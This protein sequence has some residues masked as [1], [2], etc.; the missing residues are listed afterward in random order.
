MGDVGKKRHLLVNE[1]ITFAQMLNG[2]PPLNAKTG[3]RRDNMLR[4]ASF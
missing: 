2:K 1:Q 3:N 4:L